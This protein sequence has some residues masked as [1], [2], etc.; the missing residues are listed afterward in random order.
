MKEKRLYLL[1]GALLA[2]GLL[3]AAVIA[4]GTETLMKPLI[5]LG[6][7]LR[8]LSEKS[9]VGNI[10]AWTLVLGISALP[11][12][13]LLRK[14]QRGTG[15]MLIAL[16]V[17]GAVLLAL[18]IFLHVASKGF[19]HGEYSLGIGVIL[20][21]IA[22]LAMIVV[23]LLRKW[24]GYSKTDC[25]L[26]LCSGE[27]F[28]ALFFLVN[29][30]L[31]SSELLWMGKKAISD[32]WALVSFG[33]VIATFLGWLLLR[34]VNTVQSRPQSLFPKLLFAG[35]AAYAFVLGWSLVDG[36]WSQWQYV[37]EGNTEMQR[38]QDSKLLVTVLAFVRLIPDLIGAWV[39]LWAC[40]L[41]Q[42]MGNDPFGEAMIRLA[43]GTAQRCKAAAKWS[44]LVAIGG[45]LLQMLCFSRSALLQIHLELPF[46]TLA[47][48]AA[49]FLLCGYFRRAKEIHDDNVTI[50]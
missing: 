38:I 41:V 40:D 42:T 1:L 6:Q 17:E 13:G 20:C 30:T 34:A 46:L 14:E 5:A 33:T 31:L 9:I 45:N 4:L 39:L 43:E 18:C 3:A 29:P 35:A 47:L 12:L 7:G 22:V 23:Q 24:K 15:K 26:L 2:G 36:I 10:I 50:I 11:L 25:F 28:A 27:L 48:C 44:V 21:P 49:L 8:N 16:G 19:A 37:A 32:I